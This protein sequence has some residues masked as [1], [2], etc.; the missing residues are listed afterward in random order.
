M[1]AMPAPGHDGG[2]SLCVSSQVG[3]RMGCKFCETGKMGLL[4][5]LSAGEIVSQIALAT[6]VL[7]LDV[8]NVI[9]MG[10][11]EPLDNVEAVIQSIRVLTDPSGFGLALSHITVSTSGVACHVHTLMAA[12]PAVRLAFS[13][14]AANDELRSSLMP[15]N[16]KVP[17]VELS[18]AMRAYLGSTRRRV[19]VQYVLLAG[20]NDS[21]SHAD[22]LAAL[23]AGIGPAARF[24]VNLIPF[25]ATSGKQRFAPPSHDECKAFKTALKPHGLFCKIREEKGAEKMA[26]CGQLGN[27]HLRRLLTRRRRDAEADAEA[28]EEAEEAAEVAA[29]ATEHELEMQQAVESRAASSL[30][31]REDLSW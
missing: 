13:L 31:G 8:R 7:R 10:M 29:V 5:N 19:T 4:R 6:R 30:C 2:Y 28:E 20:V 21:A 16:R 24:H 22:E 17:L 18:D 25:N 26:A 11:G 15:V 1:V 23:L 12:L 14:H 27:V 9:Y 3:C